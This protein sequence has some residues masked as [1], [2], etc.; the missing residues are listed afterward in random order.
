M[1]LVTP[2]G[3]M[4]FRLSCFL[5]LGVAVAACSAGG[6]DG[7]S[8]SGEAAH[9]GATSSA[10]RLMLAEAPL[11][12]GAGGSLSVSMGGA[13]EVPLH[14]EQDCDGVDNDRNG[15]IDDVDVG[16]DGICDCLRI[17]TIGKQGQDG[18]GNAFA[19]WLGARSTLGVVALGDSTITPE[20]IRNLQVIIT[21][22]MTPPVEAEPWQN[23]AVLHHYSDREQRAIEAWVRSGGGLMT[24]TGYA[25]YPEELNNVNSILKFT[26]IQYGRNPVLAKPDPS[27]PSIPITNWVAHPLTEGVTA[28]GFDNGYEVQGV[29]PVLSSEQGHPLLRAVELDDGHVVVWGDEWITFD[30]EW[31]NG[32]TYQVERFWQNILKWL[33]P[34]DECQVPIPDKVK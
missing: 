33:S 2:R 3:L 18:S 16:K 6:G 19:A 11:P 15:V 5:G 27:A 8:S 25:W 9:A 31:T 22:N 29:T 30:K 1:L 26:G 12:S 7:P 17:G 34:K 20:A 32:G 14:V 13:P 10:G 21:L 23:L 24:T 4:P 28:V